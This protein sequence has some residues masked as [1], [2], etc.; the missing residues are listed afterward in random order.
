[1]LKFCHC[2]QTEDVLNH[3]YV[4]EDNGKDYQGILLLEDDLTL[5]TMRKKFLS[6]TEKLRKFF[7]K[8]LIWGYGTFTKRLRTTRQGSTQ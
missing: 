1:M 6:L 7:T 8:E 2:P 3:K 4:I 5:L